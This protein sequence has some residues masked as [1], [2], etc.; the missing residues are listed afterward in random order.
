VPPPLVPAP[1][2]A[3]V[4]RGVGSRRRKFPM[5]CR[6][7]AFVLFAVAFALLTF[8]NGCHRQAE[9]QTTH[10]QTAALRSELD[11]V[12]QAN[13]DARQKAVDAQRNIEQARALLAAVVAE[14]GPSVQEFIAAINSAIPMIDAAHK[15]VAA[16]TGDTKI[17]ADSTKNAP[18][19]IGAID[20]NADKLQKER[21]REHNTLGNRIERFVK[22][23]MWWGMGIVAV[24]G[25]AGAILQ[26]TPAGAPIAAGVVGS[27]G[28]VGL[29][30]MTGFIPHLVHVF[31]WLAAK[32]IDHHTPA[33]IPATK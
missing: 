7:A 6:I 11:Q 20:V 24:L 28:H 26:F 30:L 12:N 15:D 13:E 4:M 31:G 33:P 10:N 17:V 16:I 9:A 19:Q 3:L 18:A 21:D 25:I 23:L 27:V 22:R 5:K 29:G 14:V 32:A 8:C 2:V 1:S